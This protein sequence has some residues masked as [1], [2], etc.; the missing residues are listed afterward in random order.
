ME[1]TTETPSLEH[2]AAAFMEH[3]VDSD[4]KC[5]WDGLRAAL[6]AVLE[7]T[8]AKVPHN[9]ELG[10]FECD[11]CAWGVQAL[12]THIKALGKETSDA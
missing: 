5:C 10:A 6:L 9:N 7:E 4:D 2:I 1:V 11:E 3:I 8:V 12:R